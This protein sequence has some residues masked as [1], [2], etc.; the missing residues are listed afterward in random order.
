MNILTIIIII[1]LHWIADF[2]LQTDKMAKGKS[3]NWSDLLGH[4]FL[5][6]CVWFAA[7]IFGALILR[8][9]VNVIYYFFL[10]TFILHTITDYFTSRL[11]SKLYAKVEYYRALKGTDI[12]NIEYYDK[13]EGLAVHNFFMAIGFDQLLHYIQ[14]FLTYY[15]ITHL[16]R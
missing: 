1:I 5:Y 11:N 16:S 9:S 3:K 13:Q 6:S 15:I 10:I 2:V 12:N 7:T 4:T 8:Y 14:L